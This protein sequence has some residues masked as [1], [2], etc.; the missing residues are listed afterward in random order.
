MAYTTIDDPTQFFNTIIWSGDSSSPENLTVGFQPDLIWGKLRNIGYNHQIYD[1]VRGF[2]ND[3]DLQSSQTTAEGG[4]TADQYGYIS[5]VISTGFTATKGSDGGADGYGYWNESSRTYVAWNWKANGSGS[6]NSDGSI[7]SSVSANTTAGFS[8]VSYTGT[9]SNATVGTGLNVA[10]AMVIVK[11]RSNTDSWYIYHQGIGN[12]GA[13]FLDDTS[14]TSTSSNYWQNTSPTSSVFSI[15]TGNAVN[16]SSGTFIAYCF[17]EKKGFSKFGSYVGN[18]S[19]DGSYIH[20]GFKPAFVMTKRTNS[21]SH[22]LMMDNK[23]DT[24]NV[25]DALVVANDSDSET[26]WGSDRKIDFLSNGFKCR[27]TSTGLN[28][29]GSTYIYMAFAESPFVTSTG[30]PTT[31]R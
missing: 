10:P 28:V 21:T 19:N 16:R 31:A 29:S 20:L 4:G 26:N 25:A 8:I 14:A 11:S 6:S 18:G 12:T 2:G 23:R 9:G 1:S 30:I 24:F 5:G 27:S 7:T 15:G 17:A 22:W 13:I 3:K